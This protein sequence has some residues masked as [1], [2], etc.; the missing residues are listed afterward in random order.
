[1]LALAWFACSAADDPEYYFPATEPEPIPLTY[2]ADGVDGA[3][4]EAACLAWWP[5]G[6]SCSP[7]DEGEVADLRVSRGSGCPT[8]DGGEHMAGHHESDGAAGTITVY[9]ECLDDRSLVV[10]VVAHEVGHALGVYWHVWPDCST[11]E[12]RPEGTPLACGS[13]ALMG[14]HLADLPSM[15]VPDHEAWLSRN[16]LIAVDASAP[17]TVAQ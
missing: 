5:E 13:P 6:V 16:R 7:A 12:D 17:G 11:V 2:S 14:E 1:V 8:I 10:P 3:D 9:P 15:T 4:V